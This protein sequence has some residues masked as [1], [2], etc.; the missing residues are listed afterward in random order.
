MSGGCSAALLAQDAGDILVKL[1]VKDTAE[2]GG[3]SFAVRTENG[4]KIT[5]GNHGQS[6]KLFPVNP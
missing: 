2:D 4:E 5:L 6:G 1:R 3:A